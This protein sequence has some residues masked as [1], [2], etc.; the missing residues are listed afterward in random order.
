MAREVDFLEVFLSSSSNGGPGSLEQ[1]PVG[2]YYKSL[3]RS[4]VICVF[5]DIT[6]L[7]CIFESS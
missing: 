3:P 4:P 6:I 1:P 5:K 2:E 7:C